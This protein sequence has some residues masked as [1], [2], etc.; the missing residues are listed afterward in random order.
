MLTELNAI[1]PID[2]RYR[3]KTETLAHYFSEEALIKYRVLIEVEYFIA[4]C[5]LPLPQLTGVDKNLFDALRDIYRNFSADDAQAIKEIEKT[6]NHD[7]SEEHTSELQSRENLVCRL[8][9]EKKKENKYI[10]YIFK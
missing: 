9:L 4:L 3:K 1:S 7:R 8:L 5:E 2:V 10:R 6:T